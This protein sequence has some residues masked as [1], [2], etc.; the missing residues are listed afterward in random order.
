F[1]DRAPPVI[2]VTG[3]TEGGLYNA[4]VTPLFSASDPA[5][6]TGT[7]Q[8]LLNGSPFVSGTLVSAEA[9]YTLQVTA[10][11]LGGVTSTVTV[12]FALDR[13]S[14]LISV[15]GVQAGQTYRAAVT[16]IVS[17]TDPRL[18]TVVLALDGQPYTAGV[19]VITDGAHSLVVTAFDNAGNVASST[20]TF[21]LDAPPSAPP[22]FAVAIEEGVGAVLTW[23]SPT[24]DTT[25]YRVYRDGTP[26][27]SGVLTLPRFSD[28]SMLPGAARVYE[29]AAVD[30]AG[31][32]GTKAKATLPAVDFALE[33]YGVTE[34]G[35]PALVRGFFDTVRLRVSNGSASSKLVGPA[36]LQLSS[37]GVFVASGPGPSVSVPAGGNAFTDGVLAI[38]TGLPETAGLRVT[39]TLPVEPGASATL[40]RSFSVASRAP[41][42]PIVEVFPEPLV[43]G[44]NKTVTVK[45]H[46]QG[47]APLELLS[48]NPSDLLVELRTPEGTVLSSARLSQSGNGAQG[49][50]SGFFVPVPAGGSKLLDPVTLFIPDALGASAQIR[51]R[52]D[53]VFT[54]LVAGPQQGPRAF[55]TLKAVSGVEEPPY[56]VTVVPQA[57]L[58]DQNLPVILTGTALDTADQLVP[59][60]TVQVGVSLRGFDRIASTRTDALGHYQV[61]FSPAPG[62]AGLYTLW[63][64][65]PDVVNRLPQSS[66]TIVGLGYRFSDF[67]AS[68]TQ[69]AG[70]AFRVDLVNTGQTRVEG[71]SGS[72]ISSAV[73]SGASL[74]L[75][76]ASLPAALDA[77]QSASLSLNASATSVAAL[78][79]SRFELRVTESHGFTRALPVFVDV[80]AAL[81]V[82]SATPQ[83][84]NVGM[85][86]GD[87]RRLETR[88]K[89]LGTRDWQ[90]V[91]LTQPTLSWVRVDGPTSLGD[92]P[93][94]GE[95]VVTL[96]LEPPASL[97]SQAYAANPLLSV[98]SSNAS[99]VPLNALITITASGEG[100]VA[101]TVIDADKPRNAFGVGVPVPGAELT[102]VSLD[103]AGL[104]F[105][106]VADSNGVARILNAPQGRYSYTVKASGYED[107]S[108]TELIEP[109]V[110]LEKEVLLPTN[111]V[112]YEWTVEPTTIQDQYEITLGITFKTDVPAPVV[113]IEPAVMNFTLDGGQSADAQLTVENKGLIIAR[114]VNVRPNVTDPAITIDM[115]FDSIPELLPGQKV[116]VPVRVGLL[117]ASCHASEITAGY[118]YTCAAGVDVGKSL[119][120][121][122]ISAGHC[123]NVPTA[124]VGGSSS[125]SGGFT[126]TPIV[127]SGSGGISLSVPA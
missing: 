37:A 74:T 16:P 105:R 52:V 44:T 84:F 101:Y 23:A 78:G 117:F 15:S 98:N 77:G 64:S 7:V 62:E 118:S 24:P 115:P 10:S 106:A 11:N 21:T 8:G 30:A 36:A 47:S 66:F 34:N 81:P 94:G 80:S 58:Y 90:G 4:P 104:S 19:P 97:P 59:G 76:P 2:T 56:R 1:Y 67:A 103:V 124:T 89:N 27:V 6:D 75:D 112:S 38:P 121:V 107:R 100:N 61:T 82:P 91:T 18:A 57:P 63:A 68:V 31:Q 60:A 28:P 110:T 95:K 99:A 86:A 69:N 92:I 51:A 33:S 40:R 123:F 46:N 108:G 126:S 55:E 41:R 72:V 13:S 113:T 70:Y 3:V 42:E 111:V 93:P 71:L 54:N 5:L 122:K 43:R 109:G 127:G 65:H 45:L 48:A 22:A 88:L 119:P 17:V 83:A 125:S 49:S 53:R 114:N 73:L 116:V 96:A 79:R 120:P 20:T 50:P 9:E 85:R 87:V 12:H 14:P 26:L 29:V 39:L 102:F 35:V 25:G 32:E